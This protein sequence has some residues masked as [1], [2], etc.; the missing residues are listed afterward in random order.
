[1]RFTSTIEHDTV[2]ALA[3]RVYSLAGVA[4]A[5]AKGA[6]Q[7]LLD[8]NPFLA[9]DDVPAG[10]LV[11]V[12]EAPGVAFSVTARSPDATRVAT[13]TGLVAGGIEQARSDVLGLLAEQS[14]T[15]KEAAALAKAVRAKPGTKDALGATAAAARAR[16]ATTDIALEQAERAFAQMTADLAALSQAFG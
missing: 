3:A 14:R 2:S 10:T 13:V 6:E 11:A 7:A 15:A 12:P 5:L 8:A 9:R 4:P 16:A 1:M